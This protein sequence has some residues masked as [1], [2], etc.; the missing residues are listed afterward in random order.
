MPMVKFSFGDRVV[1]AAKPEWGVGQVVGAQPISENGVSAQ[2]LTIRFDRAGLKTLST[3]FAELRPATA[4]P[5]FPGPPPPR[6]PCRRRTARRAGWSTSKMRRSTR[7][8]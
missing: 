3:G 8:R 2:R 1:H 7:S 6:T 4:G 5:L